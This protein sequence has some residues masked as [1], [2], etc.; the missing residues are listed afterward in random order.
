MKNFILDI[1]SD[2]REKRL[3]PVAV[4]LLVGLLAVPVVLSKPAEEVEP[5]APTSA[6]T[7]PEVTG[8]LLPADLE[9]AKPLLRTSTLNEFDSKDPFKPLKALEQVEQ[10]AGVE[11]AP[12]DALAQGETGGTGVGGGGSAP[13]D[14]GQGQTP[15][16]QEEE[17]TVF[18]YQAVVELTTASGAKKRVVNRLGILPRDTNPLLVFL[19]VSADNNGEAVFLVDST[20]TQAGEGRCRPSAATCSFLYLTQ[21]NGNDEHIFT[22]DDG[23]EYGIKLLKIRRVEVG[24]RSRR[25]PRCRTPRLARAR[26]EFT[27]VDPSENPL[28]GFDFPLFADEEE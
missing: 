3:W 19:G 8:Q 1:W 24:R 27:S 22:T 25:A 21:E 16:I 23:K 12:G 11:P 6:A 7:P 28:A 26:A 10:A 4:A 17:K 20:V 9:A 15:S 5:A 13:S 14:G 2:L 18:T